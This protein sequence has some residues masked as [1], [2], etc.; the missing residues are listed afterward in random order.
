ME[1][2]TTVRVTMVASLILRAPRATL[3]EPRFLADAT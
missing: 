1:E 3:P 2:G